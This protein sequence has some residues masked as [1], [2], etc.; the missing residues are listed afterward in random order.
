[1]RLNNIKK[2]FL[3]SSALLSAIS[4][5]AAERFVSFKQGDLL[6]NGQ[7]PVPPPDIPEERLTL[8]PIPAQAPAAQPSAPANPIPPNNQ[9]LP[10]QQPVAPPPQAPPPQAPPPQDAP[11]P[12]DGGAPPAEAAPG[13]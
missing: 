4:M 7:P 1:M 10:H 2:V 11:P 9:H 6:I 5:S 3:A 12:P 8:P 13:G